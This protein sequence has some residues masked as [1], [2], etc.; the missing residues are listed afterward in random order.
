MNRQWVE[1]PKFP[2]ELSDSFPELNRI[3]LQLLFNRGI[4]EPKQVSNF[5]SPEYENLYNPYLFKDMAKAVERIWEAI[6]NEQKIVVYGDYDADGVTASAVL[7][8]LFIYLNYPIVNYIPERFTE[9]YGLNLE[10]FYKFKED[11]V[12]V[13]IS[14]DCG[15]NSIDVADYCMENG[16]VLIITDHHEI[17]DQSPKSF[18][19]INPKNPD[20]TYPDSQITGVGVA[21]KLAKAMLGNMDFVIE[22]K[23]ISAEEYQ[24]EWDKWLLD[25]VAIGTVADCHSLLGENRILVKYGLKVLA[26]TKWIGLRQLLENANID[27][28]KNPPDSR[29]I[30]F[31][32]APRVNAA[33]RLE[34]ADTAL[35]L[36]TTTDFAEA[37]N[38]SN[39]IEEINK[40][41]QD[42]TGRIVSEAKEQAEFIADRKVILI[43]NEAWSKGLVG[44]VASRL[45]DQYKKPVIVL[46]K[47]ENEST[48]SARTY[49]DFNLI[50]CLKSAEQ[51]L[52]K[53]GGHKQAAGLTVLNENFDLFY[54]TILKYADQNL[55][56]ETTAILSIDAVLQSKDLNLATAED[57]MRLEP[58]GVGNPKPVF[59]IY[60][61]KVI[62]FRMV[63]SAQNHLQMQLDSD[64]T[65]FDCIG[66]SMSKYVNGL[67]IGGV[68]DIAGELMADSWQGVK[69]LKFKINALNLSK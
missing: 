67:E 39:Q 58:F 64:G 18:A 12:D 1:H 61:A 8:Q 37:I 14:V 55:S 68:V 20:D 6:I 54:S 22:Q 43:F 3:I 16:M 60:R 29:S 26:K 44:L 7:K 11:G 32:I 30:G 36:L 27:V 25:L 47:G 9:G 62:N 24:E 63:G 5:I 31:V 23:G 66:F 13:V 46:S 10:S 56:E 2:E 4:T 48:G 49:G 69:K 28:L 52:V 53:F 34:H 42:M 50:E 51:Y 21:Y 33:G 41:R 19:L 17:T 65:I 59:A 35:N 45:T 15:T 57:V 38:L 40:R